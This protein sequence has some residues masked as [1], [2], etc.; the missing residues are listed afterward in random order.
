MGGS[1]GGSAPSHTTSTVTQSSLP[2]YAAPYYKGLMK[3]ATSEVQKPYQTYQDQR[4]AD[5]NPDLL[6]SYGYVRGINEAGNPAL[7]NAQSAATNAT[8]AALGGAPQV[9]S[10]YT[11]NIYNGGVFDSAAADQYMSPY[12]Q[13]VLDRQKAAALQD[14]Q[15]SNIDRQTAYVNA[16]AFGGSR[17]AVG[18]YLAE[19]GMLNRMADIDASGLQN[20][21]LSAQQQFNADRDARLRAEGMTE[22]S[23]QFG[24]TQRLTAQ[25]A[26][27]KAFLDSIGL[28]LQGSETLGQL[29]VSAQQA[30]LDRA[31]A[32]AGIGGQQQDYEQSLLD[33]AYTDFVNQRDYLK[34]Q[35]SWYGGLLHGQ[36]IS[37]NTDVTT[38]QPG[39]NQLSQ[40]LGLGIGGYGLINALGGGG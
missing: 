15:R 16:G 14:F 29:G 24:D 8:N 20:A 19:E 13:A 34:Q 31:S 21:Y 36:P 35:L 4:I 17:S 40:A 32:L 28:G 9:S 30:A 3:A 2:E 27:Q 26:N 23:E 5:Q 6:A 7:D 18:N 11:D 38:T 37:A 25:Q 22:E 12:I 10:G 39:P 33:Q 1:K